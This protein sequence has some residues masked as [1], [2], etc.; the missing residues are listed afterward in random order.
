MMGHRE[1]MKGGDEWDA[2]TGW[3]K[4]FN[5]HRHPIKKAASRR[6]RRGEK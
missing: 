4:W 6:Y 2:F 5:I 1:K 3:R